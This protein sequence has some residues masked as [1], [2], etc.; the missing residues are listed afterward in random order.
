MKYLMKCALVTLALILP[1][2]AQQVGYIDMV[3]PPLLLKAAPPEGSLPV[4]CNKLGGGFFDGVVTPDDGKKR[5][6]TLEFTKLS[7]TLSIGSEFEAEVRLTNI[8]TSTIEIPWTADP[9]IAKAGPGPDRGYYEVGEFAVDLIDGSGSIVPLKSLSE[10]LLGSQY[11]TGSLR[12]IAP[13]EWVTARIKLK[14]YHRYFGR[15]S[16]TEGKAQLTVEWQQYRHSWS[17]DRSKC[18]GW[19]GTYRY[20]RYFNQKSQP[21]VVTITSDD[22]QESPAHDPSK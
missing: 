22:P 4:G 17:L 12:E 7:T 18:E 14:V 16:L 13:G 15:P 20:D 9:T 11:A 1:M 6:L 2:P 8:D 5:A 19:E 3:S 21:T 10:R